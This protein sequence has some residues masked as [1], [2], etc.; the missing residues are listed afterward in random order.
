MERLADDLQMPPARPGEVVTRQI[1][2]AGL[3][4]GGRSDVFGDTGWHL[5][6]RHKISQALKGL[7]QNQ[8]AQPGSFPT[9]RLP[10]QSQLVRGRGIDS[11]QVMCGDVGLQPR[12]C[13][14]LDR[15]HDKTTS[16]RDGSA[17]KTDLWSAQKTVACLA[18]SLP[19]PKRSI[20]A[21]LIHCWIPINGSTKSKYQTPNLRGVF[22]QPLVS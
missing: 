16:W 5:A 15:R 20:L 6:D 3:G 13:G 21:V 19:V 9:S 8:K 22:V 17:G 1:G 4:L 12:V 18:W 7:Q 14:F 10:G 2:K 11:S